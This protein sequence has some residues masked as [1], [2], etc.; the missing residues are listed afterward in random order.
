MKLALIAVAVILVS[1]G[2]IPVAAQ[3]IAIVNG[4]VIDKQELDLAVENIVQRSGGG[5]QD[6][7]EL[8]DKLKASLIT[9][10]VILQEA[11]KRQ[12]EKTPMF[13]QRLADLRN[14]LLR[15][16]LFVDI[17]KQTPVTEAQIKKMYNKLVTLNGSKEIKA[18]QITLQS[19]VD[20]KNVIADLKKGARFDDLLKTR[21]IDSNSKYT[22][23]DMGWINITQISPL[24]S[25][26]LDNI[27]KGQFSRTPYRSKLGWHVFKIENIRT[28]QLPPLDE[29]KSQITRQLQEEVIAKTI[30]DLCVKAKIQ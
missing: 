1:T 18:R 12:L 23:G 5:I 19:E 4:A 25:A 17:L 14:G 24:L 11:R 16:A 22:N 10:E 3:P 13:T 21:T 9:R 26:A 6:N 8:R 29:A 27:R 2:S 20:A 28:V 7:L 30:N 15:E